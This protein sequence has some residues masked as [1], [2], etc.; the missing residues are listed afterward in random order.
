MPARLA[1]AEFAKAN[2]RG[3]V[4][5]WECRFLEVM[6][7]PPRAKFQG[8]KVAFDDDEMLI[9]TCFLPAGDDS[10][11]FGDLEQGEALTLIAGTREMITRDAAQFSDCQFKSQKPR[12]SKALTR[13]SRF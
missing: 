11:R 2:Q 7:T 1:L 4:E 6:T 8:I 13:P 9:G 10:S 5:N 12:D 3:H